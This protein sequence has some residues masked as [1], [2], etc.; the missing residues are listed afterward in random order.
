MA[1][2]LIIKHN[3]SPEELNNLKDKAP[4]YGEEERLFTTDKIIG[5]K[6]QLALAV[7]KKY[8]CV[9]VQEESVPLDGRSEFSYYVYG[10][11][12]EVGLVMFVFKAL[13]SR[14]KD[15]VIEN[16]FGR[17]EVYVASY[18]EGLVQSIRS[19]L[20]FD[21]LDVPRVKRQIKTNANNAAAIKGN[22]L[23]ADKK[24]KESPTEQKVNVS[25]Q[26]LIK[27]I[28]AYFKGM[29]DGR[30]I[31]LQDALE[32]EAKNENQYQLS[33]DISST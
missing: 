26:S 20:E 3:V 29:Y 7:A 18:C 32:L 22:E 23:V 5:W 14:V 12:E 24:E 21:D 6:N 9:V 31:S 13:D 33:K 15:A 28:G 2:K 1:E 17:G 16:C 27:D 11:P 25:S 10:E 19:N 30:Y 4:A 8:D